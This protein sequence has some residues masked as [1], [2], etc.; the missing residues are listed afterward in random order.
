[1]YVFVDALCDVGAD[2]SRLF[3]PKHLLVVQMSWHIRDLHLGLAL[4]W[5]AG[6][7]VPSLYSIGCP[8]G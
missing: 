5:V 2:L 7:G 4:W 8:R 3:L 1:V 6:E